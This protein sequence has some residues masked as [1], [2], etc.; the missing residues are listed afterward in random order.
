MELIV[1]IARPPPPPN[2]FVITCRSEICSVIEILVSTKKRQNLASQSGAEGNLAPSLCEN[3]VV[4][5]ISGSSATHQFTLFSV[6][7]GLWRLPL[8]T[9]AHRICGVSPESVILK[10]PVSLE[11]TMGWRSSG[12]V[13]HCLLDR[14]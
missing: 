4:V 13:L 2:Q 6:N 14:S 1:D 10:T 3:N 5:V 7:F 8:H 11:K 12:N 9:H